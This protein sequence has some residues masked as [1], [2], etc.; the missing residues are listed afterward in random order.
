MFKNNLLA[1]WRNLKANK[2]FSLINICGLALGIA[3]SLLIFLWVRDERSKDNFETNG[4]PLYRIIE[5]EISAGSI[6]A[7]PNAPGPLAAELRRI[8]PD[9]QY[10]TPF[11][12]G[13]G[14][15]FRVGDKLLRQDGAYADSDYFNI[16]PFPLLQG[17]PATALRSPVSL[18]LSNRMAVSL[19]GSAAA[20]MGQTVRYNNTKELTVTAVFADLP[21]NVS[22]PFDFLINWPTFR[23]ENSWSK[24]WGTVGPHTIFTLKIGASPDHVRASIRH[25][26]DQYT[27]DPNYT[28]ELDIQPYSESWL[29]SQFK[30]G[31]ASGG[32]IV[33]VNLFS[34]V[35]AFILLI[36]CIN[37]M[38]L[39]TA[40]TSRRAKEI[41]VRK[42]AG[43]GRGS[44]IRQFIGEALFVT[45]LAA[46][47]ALVIVYTTLPWF[48][49][50]TGKHIS[51]PLS[52]VFWLELAALILV[53]GLVAGSYPALFLSSF[54]PIKV[55]KGS[56]RAGARINL[57]RQGLVVFQFVLSI[58]FIAATVIITRQ[59]DYIQHANLGFDRSHLLY[60]PFE[61]ALA[62]N[63][64]LF[65]QQAL[66]IPGVTGVSRI[67][68]APTSI[69]FNTAGVDWQG[70]DPHTSPMFIVAAAGY[71]LVPT[72]QLKLSQG[73]DFSKAFPTDSAGYLV[74]ESAIKL[75]HYKNPIGMP[76]S[77]WGTKG[78]IVGVLKDF[79]FAS[80]HDQ[81]QP[82]VLALDDSHLD[83]GTLLVS[84][85][86]GDMPT[87]LSRLRG[88]C[89]NIN[90]QFP[91]NYSFSD[92]QYQ[93]LYENEAIISRLSDS[94]AVLAIIISCLGLLGLALFTA[95]Q[96]AK[97]IGIRKVLGASAKGVFG[98]LSG[99][100]LRLVLIAILIASPLTWWGMSIWLQNFAYRIT[101]S[102]WMF[103]ATGG[104]AIVIAM[105][106]VSVQTVKAALA[107]PVRSLRAE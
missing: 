71:D 70:K 8:I 92:E 52:P 31:V 37:F 34:L 91:F 44:L 99:Q 24:D 58:A 106:T 49:Q 76:L 42:V 20:A 66:D 85:R 25:L 78:H 67:T 105:L 50:F 107:N 2:T 46:M 40:R 1:A 7:G 13:D 35:A 82:L 60:I 53:T 104:I 5:K 6:D 54:Q 28:F 88:L 32:R 55:L 59:V 15:L 68:E 89:R 69:S 94:F 3:C 102:W 93:R 65:K 19:F 80:L 63:Y 51:F 103:A 23:E 12:T 21:D 30:N 16:F 86:T 83:F 62:K 98:L 38:N 39:A 27:K 75:F 17:T 79:H 57:I 41:G 14:K 77:L 56:F 18:A 64:D 87:V 43:A 95:E 73:R 45:L 10:A 90:P 26:L 61:G 9:I 97:E 36:A 48:S 33:Y 100:F 81:I 11:S 96:R 47:L 22:Q 4:H 84:T 101:I 72:L 29:H 74:N